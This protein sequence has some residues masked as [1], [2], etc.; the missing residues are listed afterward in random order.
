[1]NAEKSQKQHRRMTSEPIPRLILSLSLPTTVSMAVIAL[2]TLADSYFVSALGTSAGAAVGISYVSRMNSTSA[3][4]KL[5]SLLER[6][7]VYTTSANGT[8]KLELKK[9]GNTYYGVLKNG[10]TEV[11]KVALGNESL[12]IKVKKTILNAEGAEVNQIWDVKDGTYTISYKKE[13]GAFAEKYKQ[14]EIKTNETTA[15]IDMIRITKSFVNRR[16]L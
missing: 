5:V 10:T 8:V 12:T 1:M 14:I 9:E 13:N 2:Y 4:E 3:A 11:D 15:K 6:T 16:P 7:R